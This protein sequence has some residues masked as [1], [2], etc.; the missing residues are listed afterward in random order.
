M[1]VMA[2]VKWHTYR[3]A[4]KRVGRS[5]RTIRCW[6][7]WG[8]PMGW[9]TIEGQR[10]RVVREDILLKHLRLHLVQSPVHQQ[11][12]RALRAGRAVN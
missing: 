8:M 11:R 3:T 1:V 12:M 5:E 10:T 6:R 7:Q 9:Q 2:A 4:A